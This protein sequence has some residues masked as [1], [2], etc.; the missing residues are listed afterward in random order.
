MAEVAVLTARLQYLVSGANEAINSARIIA[1]AQDAIAKATATSSASLTAQ[2]QQLQGTLRE[3]EGFNEALTTADSILKEV[4]SSTQNLDADLARLNA[5]FAEGQKQ[6]QGLWDEETRLQQIRA[7]ASKEAQA[8][9]RMNGEA[10]V[11]AKQRLEETTQALNKNREAQK[12]LTDEMAKTQ[13]AATQLGQVKALGPAAIK[14]LADTEKATK[15]LNDQLGDK[16]SRQRRISISEL[17][18]LIGILRTGRISTTLLG[19]ETLRLAKV[20]AA[21]SSGAAG[22]RASIA[23]LS[24]ASKVALV[25]LAALIAVPVVHAI[26][27]IKKAFS[28]LRGEWGQMAEAAVVLSDRIKEVAASLTQIN[29]VGDIEL[30]AALEQGT[31]RFGAVGAVDPEAA[32]RRAAELANTAQF[33]RPGQGD[34]TKVFEDIQHAIETLN[35]TPL[36][37]MGIEV[38][39]MNA[40]LNQLADQGLSKAALRTEAF[41]LLQGQLARSAGAASEQAEREGK[42]FSGFLKAINN[43]KQGIAGSERFQAAYK[44]ITSALHSALPIIKQVVSFLAGA[45]VRA[46]D[47]TADAIR[48]V[49]PPLRVAL[50]L[51]KL[52]GTILRP[53]LRVIGQIATAISKFLSESIRGMGITIAWVIDRLA[54][55]GDAAA[56][57]FE[58]FGGGQDLR[59]GADKFRA[60]AEEIRNANQAMGSAT[61]GIGELNDELTEF[62]PTA[63]DAEQAL[64]RFYDSVRAGFG[65]NSA[66][67]SLATAFNAME[68]DFNPATALAYFEALDSAAGLLAEHGSGALA[69]LRVQLESFTKLGLA[70]PKALEEAI[71]LVENAEALAAPLLAQTRQVE[72]AFGVTESAAAKASG[73]FSGTLSPSIIGIGNAALTA[74]GQVYGLRDAILSIPSQVNTNFVISGVPTG[75]FV[76]GAGV[77]G[78]LRGPTV[79]APTSVGPVALL[80]PP[81]PRHLQV[82][83]ALGPPGTGFKLPTTGTTTTGSTGGPPGRPFGVPDAGKAGADT[84]RAQSFFDDLRDRFAFLDQGKAGGGGAAAGVDLEAIRR[85][86][87]A[88]NQAI[89]IGLRGGVAFSTSGNV[90]PTFGPETFLSAQGGLLV[91]NLVIR[92]V[93]DFADPTA[94]RQILREL[95]SLLNDLRREVK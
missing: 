85:L 59:R 72:Q 3:L 25:G 44:N 5:Q 82:P 18:G 12:S 40:R 11:V 70:P 47:F 2:A 28:D 14:A 21:S 38:E 4:G 16:G 58:L 33:L 86:I 9:Q 27:Q 32:A 73:V 35:F 84:L 71:R 78:N 15:R 80:G 63:E 64:Q 61:Q 49:L 79:V 93:W 46:W 45:T 41:N 22:F 68:E 37:D 87:D 92:G 75:G 69:D 34:F 94:K 74:T 39:A 52:L 24:V 91:E 89:L 20:F 19:W 1:E 81:T 95:E 56:W 55:L 57:F 76:S 8:A 42:T 17:N 90:I 60:A 29:T 6:L 66:F 54:D 48:F 65:L 53:V 67:D 36:R 7:E 10:A 31:R 50:T 77:G 88:V 62:V 30:G 13:V 51:F 26:F 83:G 23:A 43:I